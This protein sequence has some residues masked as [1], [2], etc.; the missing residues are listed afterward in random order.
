VKASGARSARRAR[1]AD[2]R[3]TG[4]LRVGS[5]CGRRAPARSP[6]SVFSLFSHWRWWKNR[7][8]DLP[9]SV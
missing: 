6:D 7:A 3:L 8:D 1:P 9:R 5:G 4:R 2:R